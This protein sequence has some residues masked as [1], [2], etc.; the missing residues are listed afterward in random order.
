MK[1]AA[2]EVGRTVFHEQGQTSDQIRGAAAKLKKCLESCNGLVDI[3][4][5]KH[6]TNLT[7]MGDFWSYYGLVLEMIFDVCYTQD[8][9]PILLASGWDSADPYKG[10]HPNILQTGENE[11]GK[12]FNYDTVSQMLVQGL[13]DMVSDSTKGARKEDKS[14]DGI[15]EVHEEANRQGTSPAP[16]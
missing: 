16:L 14:R 5:P 2:L 11:T 15:I 4:I 6:S 1:Q 3:I 12:S 13:M 10:L 8:I 7:L 9:I